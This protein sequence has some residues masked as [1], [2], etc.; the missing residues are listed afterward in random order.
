MADHSV[1][2]WNELHESEASQALVFCFDNAFPGNNLELNA[3]QL[4]A[5]CDR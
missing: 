1:G 2:A 3:I 5:K 4:G